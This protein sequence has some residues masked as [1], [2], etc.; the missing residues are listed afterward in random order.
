MTGE[1]T[2]V[3]EQF[4]MTATELGYGTARTVASAWRA[5]CLPEATCSLVRAARALTCEDARPRLFD[6]EPPWRTAED[7]L[8]AV[9]EHEAHAVTLATDVLKMAAAC[10]NARNRAIADYHAAERP[11]ERAQPVPGRARK[12]PLLET[13]VGDCDAALDLLAQVTERL[14]Y[15]ID[16]F[17]RTPADFEEAYDVVLQHVRDGGTLPWSG[18]FLTGARR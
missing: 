12:R 15:A 7:F 17:R 11:P 6:R 16:C 9:E 5:R 2:A 4:A 18:D 8:A 10:E 3:A 1:W 14:G 13:V